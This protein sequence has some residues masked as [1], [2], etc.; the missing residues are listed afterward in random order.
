[1]YV[2]YLVTQVDHWNRE[3]NRLAD[4]ARVARDALNAALKAY[5]DALKTLPSDDEGDD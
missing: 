4:L 3:A 1:M 5:E 2:N